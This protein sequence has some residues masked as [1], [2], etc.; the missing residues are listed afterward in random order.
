MSHRTQQT[1]VLAYQWLGVMDDM[2]AGDEFR[3]MG[4]DMKVTN[5]TV[6]R[7]GRGFIGD[8]VAQ[9][10]RDIPECTLLAVV[11][12]MLTPFGSGPS[13][14]EVTEVDVLVSFTGE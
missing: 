5:Y 12:R 2:S 7:S 8:N 14:Y 1:P 13:Q 3:W 11:P 9:L 6:K 10:L 4:S